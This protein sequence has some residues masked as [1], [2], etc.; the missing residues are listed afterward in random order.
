MI[1]ALRRY[2]QK[3]DPCVVLDQ[4]ARQPGLTPE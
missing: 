1:A 2:W 3:I 4:L